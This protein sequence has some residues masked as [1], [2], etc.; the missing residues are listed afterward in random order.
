MN[1]ENLSW[2]LSL[3][4]SGIASYCFWLQMSP[5]WNQKYLF[6]EAI[7]ATMLSFTAASGA[8]LHM[9]H[10]SDR[11]RPP[12]FLTLSILLSLAAVS[13]IWLT[14]DSFYSRS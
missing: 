9:L 2:W 14:G 1:K 11:L 6:P 3:L 7:I 4:F 8:V 12:V 5:G 13:W 10:Y